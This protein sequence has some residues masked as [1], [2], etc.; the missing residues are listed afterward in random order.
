MS[1]RPIPGRVYDEA[2]DYARQ[3]GHDDNAAQWH[4]EMVLQQMR[5]LPE[6]PHKEQDDGQ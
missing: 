4:A 5:D 2:Y 6:L 3:H 1:R